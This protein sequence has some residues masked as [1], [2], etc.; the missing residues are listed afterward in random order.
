MPNKALL[1]DARNALYRAIYAVK[2]DRRHTIKYHYFVI[3][4]RQLS[5]WIGRFNPSSVHIFWDAPK[6]KVW[7]RLVLETYKDRSNSQ[8]VEDISEDLAITTRVAMEILPFM[9]VR[10]YFKA[11][12]EAD[13]LIYAA[14]NTIHPSDSVIISTDSDMIQMPFVYPTVEVWDPKKQE[15]MS[16][17]HINPAA[18]KA[19]MGD[20]ADSIDGYRGI[21]PK[22]SAAMLEGVQSLNEFLQTQGSQ[23][24][25]R[26]LLL[27]DLSLCPRLLANRKY[28]WSTMQK[29][30]M[31]DKKKIDELVGK[32]KVMG[33][34]SEETDL[35][36]PFLQLSP[37][38]I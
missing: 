1:V 26:N 30:I 24:Y 28:V 36:P 17:P 29:P 38:Q 3:F 34:I 37:S 14:V 22:K 12:M 18:Q 21:G 31:W 25:Y 35:L 32:Y 6:T 15:M 8:Y 20:K 27:I 5:S 11:Q 2:A 4:L 10:Q 19:L 16:V 33:F 9:N 13:D 23:L 7:R